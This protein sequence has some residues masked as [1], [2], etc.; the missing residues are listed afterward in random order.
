MKLY[1][2]GSA[3]ILAAAIDRGAT[4]KEAVGDVEDWLEGYRPWM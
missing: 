3:R 1:E 4:A 2:P